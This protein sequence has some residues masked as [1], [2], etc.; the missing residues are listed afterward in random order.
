MLMLSLKEKL[1]VVDANRNPI[2]VVNRNPADVVANLAEVV[3]K[4]RP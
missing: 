3:N 2:A 4:G 1:L